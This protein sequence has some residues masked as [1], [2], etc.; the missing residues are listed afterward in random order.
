MS[1]VNL[2][3]SLCRPDY[4][5]LYMVESSIMDEARKRGG[6]FNGTVSRVEEESLPSVCS[7]TSADAK[8][9]KHLRFS[10]DD[11]GN[12]TAAFG[13]VAPLKDIPHAIKKS[14]KRTS[15]CSSTID[16][17]YRVE[18]IPPRMD[19]TGTEKST[20][21]FIPSANPLRSSVPSIENQKARYQISSI[22]LKKTSWLRIWTCKH[23]HWSL[24]FEQHTYNT[25]HP[26]R[27]RFAKYFL[28][29]LIS[30]IPVIVNGTMSH[31]HSGSVPATESSTW[32]SY[33]MQ[34]LVFGLVTGIWWVLDQ[35]GKDASPSPKKYL[36]P[37]GR[38]L[39]YVLSASP[40]VG[41]FIVVGQMVVEYGVCFWVGS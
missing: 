20:L 18:P 32:K 9:I 26:L 33:T 1:I 31:F 19:Y 11:S 40:A 13:T 35:E 23:H 36:G 39:L 24:S 25:L 6:V 14:E 41:G 30:L 27:W 12:L 34:W 8:D 5:S 21:I 2:I 28:T 10:T 22:T 3:G 7:C 17:S 15:E 38:V 16:H 37:V 4:T 29:E